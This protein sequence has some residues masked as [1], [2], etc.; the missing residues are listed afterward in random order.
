MIHHIFRRS[1]KARFI[2]MIVSILLIVILV[3]TLVTA[4][5]SV[6]LLQEESERQL[7][8]SLFQSAEMLSGFI[9][10]RE[11]NI[12]IWSSNPLIDA[13]FGDPALAMVFVPSLHEYFSKIREKEPWISNIFLIQKDEVVYDDSDSFEFS[14]GSNGKPVGIKNLLSVPDKGIF[15]YNMNQFNHKLNKNVIIIKRKVVKNGSPANENFIVLI[16]DMNRVN[17]RLFGNIHIGRR[18]FV[19]MAAENMSGQIVLSASVEEG[20]EKSCFLE[21]GSQWKK[22][23]DIPD[24][25]NFILLRK[26][27]L[28]NYSLA[29]IGVASLND[30]REPVIYLVYLSAIFSLLASVIGIW[31][32]IF[33][34][35]KLISPIFRLIHTIKLISK[36]DLT[37]R[38]DVGRQDEI[39]ILATV[40]NEMTAKL[41]KYQNHLEEMVEKRTAELTTEIKERTQAEDALRESERKFYNIIDFL[42][43]ATVVIDK[44]GKVIA[45][46]KAVEKMTRVKA[47]NILGKGNHE[48]AIP[49]YGERRAILI[50]LAVIPDDELEKKYPKIIRD[51]GVLTGESFTP[52]LPGGGAYL[53][54]TASALYDSEGNVTGAIELIR[55]I[56]DRKKAEDAVKEA[57]T[58]AQNAR[59]AA[60]QANRKITESIVYAKM[61]QRSLLAN[62]DEVKSYLPDSFF[63]W[64]REIL[65]VVI[66]FI[67]MLLKTVLLL[68]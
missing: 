17:K 11:I 40:F 23:S 36:G 55:D 32:A 12:D 29:V 34:S 9:D 8:Q 16:L 3:L 22:F 53:F 24:R 33:F 18:G 58:E 47:E 50:D 25:Y 2:I 49:F 51:K 6:R 41:M 61:I 14:D 44:D 46:N 57:L 39:G 13:I 66:F 65:S 67:Q 59:E 42:P 4:F 1:I 52:N 38:A 21:T 54:A 62:L 27:I 43:D 28:P 63:V 5:T 26:Q 60:E 19:A 7:S 48:Y 31:C 68:Q 20:I 30:I 15:V 35:G 10:A 56:T 37:Q 64:S 45:W